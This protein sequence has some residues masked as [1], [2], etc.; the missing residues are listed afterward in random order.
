MEPIVLDIKYSPEDLQKSY[1]LHYKVYYPVRSKLLLILG[2]LLIVVGGLLFFI[3]YIRQESEWLSWFYIVLGGLSVVY[4]FWKISTM[5]KK[6]FRRMPDFQASH[7][8]IINDAGVNGKSATMSS[9]VK[10]EHYKEAVLASEMILLYINPFRFNIF[11]K[12]FFKNGE[13][14]KLKEIVIS[15]VKPIRQL[16]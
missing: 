9:E 15:K 16:K 6:M 14:E 2:I 7:N 8:F 1:E 4:H 12:K 13:F 5:G 11:P 3:D 10:W